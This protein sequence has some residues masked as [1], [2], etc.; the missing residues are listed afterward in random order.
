MRFSEPGLTPSVERSLSE[1][2]AD[3]RHEWRHA[4][5]G[6][7]KLLVVA[8]LPIAIARVLIMSATRECVVAMRSPFAW[9]WIASSLVLAIVLPS[10]VRGIPFGRSPRLLDIVGAF[11]FVSP[12][13]L[14]LVSLMG[15]RTVRVPVA[16]MT[17]LVAFVVT[18]VLLVGLPI[19]LART[20]DLF[21]NRR[22][23]V[24]PDWL[25]VVGF[26]I[27]CIAFCWC[28]L[29]LADRARIHA[30]RAFISSLAILLP[31][32]GLVLA[33]PWRSAVSRG[34][35]IAVVFLAAA[36]PL[37]IM[38]RLIRPSLSNKACS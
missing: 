17:T 27:P 37:A 32:A 33:M 6:A 1:L 18:G 19:A 29:N 20:F 38:A 21:D 22:L 30:R 31:I 5:S 35:E 2:T 10:M 16:G 4:R 13:T 26:A 12:A 14:L 9:R 24:M 3:A 28:A 23:F 7:M 15:R 11:L 25:M 8:G 36:A 34:F